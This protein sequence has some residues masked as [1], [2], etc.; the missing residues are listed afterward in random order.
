[1]TFSLIGII[2][3]G[4]YC[5]IELLGQGGGG[6]LYLARDLELGQLWAVKEI[7][8]SGKKEAKLLR[9]LEHPSLPK[10]VDYLERGEFCYLV[11][12]YI[13]GRSLGEWLREGRSFSFTEIMEFGIGAAQVLNYLHTRKPPVYYGDLKPDNLMLSKDGRLYLVDLG[14]AV[15]GYCENHRLCMGTEGYAAPE[16]YQGNMS[17]AS[18]VYALGKTLAELCGKKQRQYFFRYP[19]LGILILRCCRRQEGQRIL[20]TQVERELK[21]LLKKR[22]GKS[23]RTAAAVS[24]AVFIGLAAVGIFYPK[25][26]PFAE[27]LSEVTEIYYNEEFLNGNREQQK[28]FTR[29][30][31][32]KLH[33]LLKEYGEKE[34]QRRLLLLLAYNGELLGETERAGFYY[35]QLLLYDGNFGEAYGEYGLFL[36][37]QGKTEEAQRLWRE[38]KRRT[39]GEETDGAKSREISLWKA[40]M[41]GKPSGIN[42]ES[43]E[44]DIEEERNE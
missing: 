14:S 6:H 44:T 37:R 25:K 42:H 16:Q 36:L 22:G 11:M 8:L 12:E 43:D 7:P 17:A 2:L 26:L 15:F 41:E 30:V 35:R 3:K 40:Q 38:Y 33:G 1:M 18:D 4:R 23:S 28:E 32:K 27:A 24:V 39:Q 34:E 19:S 5:V 31:E 9:L 10:M 20:M 13:R 21:R 29:A